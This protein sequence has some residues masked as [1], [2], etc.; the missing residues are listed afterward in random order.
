MGMSTQD[1]NPHGDG[2]AVYRRASD[3]PRR[4]GHA[5][6]ARCAG[7][8]QFADVSPAPGAAWC[9][10]SGPRLQQTF[11]LLILGGL[12]LGGCN[13]LGV[14][15][16]STPA[17]AATVAAP[18]PATLE[19]DAGAAYDARDWTRSEVLYVALT[20]AQPA[21]AEPWFKLG[22]IY[23]RTDRAELAIRAFREAINRDPRHIRAWHNLGV[24]QLRQAS[25]SFH[26]LTQV[27][28]PDAPLAARG[29]QLGAAVD[30]LLAEDPSAAA[31]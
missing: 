22:N 31:P 2:R 19:R 27:A 28:P 20:R 1:F 18:D 12:M 21:A 4:S 16:A 9:H 25:A 10:R 26:E 13:R 24:T 29:Q 8:P 14:A 3:T 30:A 11:V 5:C 15:P 23:A 17:A 6:V 7:R